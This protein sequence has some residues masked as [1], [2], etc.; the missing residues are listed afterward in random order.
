MF[1]PG[2][3]ARLVIEKPLNL[4]FIVQVLIML[5]ILFILAVQGQAAAEDPNLP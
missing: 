4:M 1:R 2:K 5:T 3:I